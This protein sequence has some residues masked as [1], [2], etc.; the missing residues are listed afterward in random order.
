MP[1]AGE[2]HPGA[3]VAHEPHGALDRAGGVD[4]PV[5]L[6]PVVLH[7][8]GVRPTVSLGE[9]VVAALQRAVGAAVV[10]P[11]H[12]GARQHP[13]AGRLDLGNQ[14]VDVGRA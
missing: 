13:A 6:N 5:S 9:V 4:D 7:P 2:H 14:M 1:G 3:V 8:R 12:G 10:D 11:E